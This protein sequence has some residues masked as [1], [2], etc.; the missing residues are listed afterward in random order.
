MPTVSYPFDTTGLAATNRI[1]DEVHTLTEVNSNTYRIIIPEFAPFYLD[2]FVFK[3]VDQLGVTTV[4]TEGIHYTLCLPYIGATRS[5]GKMLYGGISV[6]DT[7]VNG[8]IKITYQTLGGDWTADAA[9]VLTA[10][11]ELAYNPRVTA[12]DVV[13]NKQEIFPPTVHNQHMDTVFG[14]EALINKIQELIAAVASNTGPANYHTS[15]LLDDNNPHMTTALQVGLGN[16]ADLPLA[17]DAEVL[18]RS[19]VDKYITLRQLLLLLP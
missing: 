3:H 4:L 11:A 5:T 17:S 18:A 2:N 1:V 7:I 16:V 15:H 10:L 8:T 19:P 13:T 12:W 9:Y 6:S 14:H